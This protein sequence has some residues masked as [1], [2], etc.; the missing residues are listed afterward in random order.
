MPPRRR[1]RKKRSERTSINDDFADAFDFLPTSPP[2]KPP[3]PPPVAPLGSSSLRRSSRLCHTHST[4][5]TRRGHE[6]DNDEGCIQEAVL[7]DTEA[8][9]NNDN[10]NK[11]KGVDE[12]EATEAT[13]RDPIG[14]GGGG[15]CG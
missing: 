15:G 8:A 13:V 3:P 5:R 6:D 12:D 2:P 7:R 11:P 14:D 9:E 10:T 4:R 1:H